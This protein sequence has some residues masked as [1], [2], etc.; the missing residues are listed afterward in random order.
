MNKRKKKKGK[1]VIRGT[2][3]MFS[4]LYCF[5]IGTCCCYYFVSNKKELRETGKIYLKQFLV[6]VFNIANKGRHRRNKSLACANIS[7]T[8]NHCKTV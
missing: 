3:V 2:R 6:S 8:N 7:S 1:K 4:F 5:M